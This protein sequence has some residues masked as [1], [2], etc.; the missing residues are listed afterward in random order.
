MS[1][2]ELQKLLE[3]TVAEFIQNLVG[4]VPVEYSLEDGD[5]GTKLFNVKISGDNVGYIIGTH[6][7]NIL[8]MQQILSMI[9]SRKLMAENFETRV[10]V[11]VDVGDYRKARAEKI[12]QIALR[13]A[14]DARILG[15]TIDLEPMDPAD[16]RIVHM[17]LQKFDDITTQ[18]VGEGPDRYVQ[19]IPKSED[20]LGVTKDVEKSMDEADDADVASEEESSEE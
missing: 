20:D 13:K 18:S 15:D 1:D 10:Y 3:E 6:G 5:E 12:E 7:K 2:K 19:I 11:L 17:T 4:E 14:D 8:S 9:V 16:R